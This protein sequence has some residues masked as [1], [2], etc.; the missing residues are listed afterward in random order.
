MNNFVFP[1]IPNPYNYYLEELKRLKDR[2]TILEEKIKILE[3]KNNN[4]Y[5]KKDDN[6]YMI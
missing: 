4:N 6:Y 5:L 2:I 1:P 3:N